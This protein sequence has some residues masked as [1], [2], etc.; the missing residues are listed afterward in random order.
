VAWYGKLTTGSSQVCVYDERGANRLEFRTR[1]R[2]VARIIAEGWF[3]G[4]VDRVTHL[5][6]AALRGLAGATYGLLDDW[7]GTGDV[8]RGG[9]EVKPL[10]NAWEQEAPRAA[11]TLVLYG[12]VHG[13]H[14]VA[15]LF[16]QE[17]KF[18]NG[19]VLNKHGI[20]RAKVA[21]MWGRVG[22]AGEVR[23]EGSE[24]VAKVGDVLDAIVKGEVDDAII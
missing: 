1:K 6:M 24:R 18:L 11:K 13:F 14:Q 8:L 5:T 7:L 23:Q 4:G 17:A 10:V 21:A 3:A 15:M 12:L 9:V 22:L 20:E 19:D 2:D 16:A